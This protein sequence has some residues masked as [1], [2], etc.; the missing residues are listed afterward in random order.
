MDSLLERAGQRFHE[1]R[2]QM[3]AKTTYVILGVQGSGTNL[4]R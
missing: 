4:L 1:F 3:N 2:E